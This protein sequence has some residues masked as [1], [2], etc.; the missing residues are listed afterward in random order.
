MLGCQKRSIQD[1]KNERLSIDFRG[2]NN[3]G[4]IR[5]NTVSTLKMIKLML[6]MDLTHII[7]VTYFFSSG[8]CALLIVIV[9]G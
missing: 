3:R 5:V 2:P 4:I 6:K 8:G 7:L 1:K 9:G